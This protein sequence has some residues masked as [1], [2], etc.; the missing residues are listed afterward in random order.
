M[1]G[2]RVMPIA[3]A[4]GPADH[5]HRLMISTIACLKKDAVLIRLFLLRLVHFSTPT[6]DRHDI[7]SRALCPPLPE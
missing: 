4:S 5:S 7:R 2:L 6:A 1:Q 3:A